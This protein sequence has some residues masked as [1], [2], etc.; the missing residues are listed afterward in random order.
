MAKSHLT[1]AVDARQIRDSMVGK[2][3]Y[4][5]EVV[6]YLG[7]IDHANHYILYAEDVLPLKLPANFETVILK[8]S[9]G[10]KQLWLA[11]DAKR[12]GCDVLF[13]PTAYLPVLFS[14][15]PAVLTVHDLAPFVSPQ[16]KP[17]WRTLLAER[18]LLGP[19]VRRAQQ[20]IAVSEGTKRDIEKVFG[21]KGQ[22][23]TVTPLGYDQ[24]RFMPP[25]SSTQEQDQETLDHF[26][27]KPG[28]LLFVGTL[29]PRK[30]IVGLIEAYGQLSAASRQ[31]YR[32]VIGGGKGW[33]Y[34]AIF[35]KVK[36]LHLE[37]EITFLGRVDDEYLPSLYRQAKLFLFPSF[38][39]GFGL[40][41]LE[42]LACGTPL[43]AANNSSLPEV[44]G[45]AGR[46]ADAHDPKTIAQAIEALLTDPDAYAQVKALTTKQ[47]SHFNWR[48]TAK[49]TLE[50]LK[51]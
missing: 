20:L 22:K 41:P 31:Q 43:V 11:R 5:T 3:R 29:E 17:A 27:L 6:H 13:A 4:I 2:V 10:L 1:I 35:A 26:K 23:I 46:L 9:L 51:S 24:K 33:F 50:V 30:N 42:A 40:P 48:L 8:K 7:E 25:S 38:Y 28:Y 36:E 45:E 18:L 49:A 47:A 12:R 16:A 15:I 14:Q 44:V 34:E 19:A 39:E 37:E 21:V 32:L